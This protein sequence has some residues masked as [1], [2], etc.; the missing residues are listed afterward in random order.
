MTLPAQ[1]F[2][3][4]TTP[5]ADVAPVQIYVVSD[6][7]Y[8]IPLV[9]PDYKIRI[10]GY[11]A[12]LFGRKLT[13]PDVSAPYLGHAG[14]LIINGKNGQS[15]Y[16]EY[17]R[18]PGPGPAGRVRVGNIPDVV[19]NDGGA[20]TESSLKKTLRHISSKHGQSGDI[21]GIVLRGAVFDKALSWLKEKEAENTKTTRKEYDLGNHNCITFATDLAEAVGFS[22]PRRF[23]AVVPTTYMMQFQISEPDLDYTFATDTLEITE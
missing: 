10:D 5:V 8:V 18:Y 7:D 9:F 20:I 3:I 17:G 2:T 23:L 4:A 19:L 16:Y 12:T 1:V 11:Q 13:I 22:I 14:V 21:T 6:L 15:K